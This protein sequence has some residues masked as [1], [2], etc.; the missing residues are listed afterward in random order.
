[1]NPPT[2]ATPAPPRLSTLILLT[3]LSTV[4]L[5]IFVPSMVNIAADLNSDYSVVSL[6]VG[7]YLAA[8]TIVQLV[9][10]PLSDRIG[11]R[12]VLLGALVFFAAASIGCALAPN[13]QT[14]LFF[15]MLQSIMV[16]G[17]VL[18][19]AVVRDTTNEQDSA[20]RIGYIS[21]AMAM[22]PLLGPVV[23]GL[24]DTQFGWRSI[25]YT[26]AGLGVAL[27]FWCL[28]D[29]EETKAAPVVS[30][31]SNNETIWDLLKESRFWAYA[32][33]TTF[34]TANLYIFLTGAPLIAELEFGISTTEMGLYLATGTAGYMFGS[35]L[36]GRY[37][38]TTDPLL[39]MLSGRV[40]TVIGLSIAL[41][42]SLLNALPVWL[43]FASI[44]A[45]GIGNGLTMPSSN[46]RTMSIRPALA[47]GAAGVSGAV[48]VAIGAPLSML[49]GILLPDENASTALLILMLLV[50]I[51][52]LLAVF[53]AKHI[54]KRQDAVS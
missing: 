15:R 38:S 54:E 25:F 12:P 8:M 49:T 9:V 14:F 37:A 5:N 22:A 3:A 10:G 7:I 33:C 1:M 43:F 26:L 52:S 16:A 27:F 17:Y 44:V 6:S 13:V 29:L 36:S 30:A 46:A 48:I 23:G 2:P 18:S 40:I 53:W 47:G 42:A 4:T 51:I 39:M 32:L 50:T 34:S 45:V 31:D 11:R 21:M 35:Y 41:V 19:M 24:L 20:S 28:K